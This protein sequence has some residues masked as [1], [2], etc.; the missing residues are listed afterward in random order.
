[1]LFWFSNRCEELQKI[2]VISMKVALITLEGGGISTV[3][4]GLANSLSK[5]K[6][7][8][9]IFT[10]TSGKRKVENPNEFLEINRFYRFDV[11][12]RFFWFQMQNFRFLSKALKD[13]T[14]VHGVSPDASVIF[15]FYKRKLGKPFIASFHSVPISNARKFVNTPVSSWT[16]AEF[17]HHILEYPLH[18]FNIRRCLSDADRI[19]VCSRTALSEFAAAYKDSNLKKI[20]VIYNCVNFDEINDVRI[21]HDNGNGQTGSSVIF[22]GRLFWL[23]GTAYLLKA[24]E[25]LK[26]DFKDI[27]L[28]IFGRG[29]EEN[30]M[31][32]FVSNAGLSDQ[33][34]FCGHL[35]HKNLIAEIKK[36][37]AVI[38]PSLHE[39][40]SLFVLEAMACKK[41]VIAFD[42]PPTR[43]IIKNGHNGFLAKAFDAKAL[44]EKVRLVLSDRKL[45]LKVGQNGYNYVKRK[46]NWETQIEEYLNI[47]KSV[48]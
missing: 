27:N 19:T 29:P 2:C 17:A 10:G 21:R 9:T 23:K 30:R 11:P 18:N 24:F 3:C 32:Q 38:A 26:R 4:Y 31:K 16:A 40:Q 47:Y 7:P 6:I 34:H 43:E 37:D 8:T 46:H 15:T 48:I 22:A 42:I 12:P 20:T 39:A 36:S 5:K 13:Y 44:S 25:M 35:P 14:L 41:P 33:V 28:K 1:M 45:R